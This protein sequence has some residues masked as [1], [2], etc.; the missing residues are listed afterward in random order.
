MVLRDGPS[1]ALETTCNRLAGCNGE[2][3]AY[4]ENVQGSAQLT[5]Y[6]SRAQHGTAWIKHD[7]AMHGGAEQRQHGPQKRF[8]SAA[9]IQQVLKC[10]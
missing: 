1:R 6:G 3:L 4:A 5:A 9:D 2:V 10:Q 7:R 8:R